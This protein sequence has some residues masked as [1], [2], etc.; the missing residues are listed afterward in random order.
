[1]ARCFPDPIVPDLAWQGYAG[2][3][4][5]IGWLHR[6]TVPRAGRI[7]AF[8]NRSLAELPADAAANL[9]H[10]LRHDPPFGRVYF[11][12]IVGRFLQVL[13]AEVDHQPVGIG[14]VN[15]DWRATFPDGAT[16]L[17]E[18]TSPQYNQAE[19]LEVARRVA[20]VGIIETETPRGWWVHPRTLPDL[21]LHEARG[22]FRRTVRSLF[23]NL[24]D[25]AG[26][27]HENKLI[28]LGDSSR[29]PV[30]LELWPGDPTESPM[31]M[32]SMGAHRDDSPLHIRAAVRDKRRQARAFPGEA[33]LLAIDAPFGGPDVEDFDGEL[34]GQTVMHLGIDQGVTGYSFRPNGALA[35]QRAAEYAGVLAFGRLHMFGAQDPV[36]YH[37]PRFAGSLPEELLELR[38]RSLDGSTIRDEAAARTAIMD[39]IGFAAADD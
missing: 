17:V 2:E 33:V 28:R 26:Y 8:L 21:G 20:L 1:M 3:A 30:L 23:A 24:P 36:L 4:D 37:H 14:D 39:A 11:E 19:H 6:S 25:P 12:L 38:Q 35:T 15:V 27:S 34:F 18:A 5:P 32:V 13:G 16:V 10:R 7:R 31:A 9:C 22:P 29:G